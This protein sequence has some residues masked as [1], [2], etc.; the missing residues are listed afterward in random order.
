MNPAA[1]KLQ[2][3]ANTSAD[4]NVELNSLDYEHHVSRSA[5]PQAGS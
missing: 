4:V 2:T 5:C 1:A 3:I